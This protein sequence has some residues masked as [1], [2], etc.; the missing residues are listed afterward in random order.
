MSITQNIKDISRL[1]HIV[2]VLFKY[3]F[4]YFISK[5]RLTEHLPLPK[6]LQKHRFLKKDTPPFRVAAVLEEL[7]GTFIKLG[8]LLSLRPDLIPKE[9]CDEFSKLQDDVKPFPTEEAKKI[10]ETELKKSIKELFKNF[11]DKPIAAASIGQVH[12]AQL[13]NGHHVVLKIQRPK[14]DEQMKTDI[15][16]LYHLA[17]IA[18]KHYPELHP[19][20]IIEEFEH[21]TDNELDY[22]KEAKNVDKFHHNFENEKNIKIPKVY[23][24]Y[25][26]SKVL[27]L[28]YI[29]G[30]KL[31]ESELSDKSKKRVVKIVVN[32]LFTQIFIHG[33]FH[34]DL[35]PGNIFIMDDERIA[36]L[37]FGIVGRL[38][39]E[40][41]NK[42]LQLFLAITNGNLTGIV[43]SLLELGVAREEVDE[44]QL[45]E[46]LYETLG[47]YY[48]TTLKQ[49]NISQVFQKIITL[50]K[51][52]NLRLPTNFVLL[53]KSLITVEGFASEYDPGFNIIKTAQP[54]VKK[55]TKQ[56]L[57]PKYLINSIIKT[58]DKLKDFIVKVPDHATLL[59]NKIKDQDFNIRKIHNDLQNLVV[60][61][62]KASNRLVLGLIIMGLLIASGFMMQYNQ[63][64]IYGISALSFIGFCISGF[65]IILLFIPMLKKKR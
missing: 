34:A 57:K 25:T 26:T 56:R 54:F 17:H 11:E 50:T 31:G 7:G 24:D 65:L 10:V 6:R 12:K 59:V 2:N 4:G 46:D 64:L 14:I 3:E 61:L 62:N 47:E 18:E 55:L 44:E 43:N 63:V 60:Q 35:H 23:F 1:Q 5:F 19:V 36:F 27:T 48:G 33:I 32:S 39:E 51:K 42:A 41:R 13:Q 9:F 53:A 22:V 37:D 16:I 30:K 38:N 28:E 45:K 8:Q 40:F 21:Y 58:S 15:D 29:D 52:H 49:V 20:E